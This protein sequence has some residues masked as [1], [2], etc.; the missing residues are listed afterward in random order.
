MS[1]DRTFWTGAEKELYSDLLLWRQQF[2]SWI[3][4]A[5]NRAGPRWFKRRISQWLSARP[6]CRPSGWNILIIWRTSSISEFEGFDHRFKIT[7]IPPYSTRFLKF[8]SDR[9]V[10]AP[11]LIRLFQ[12]PDPISFSEGHSIFP[13]AEVWWFRIRYFFEPG[14]FHWPRLFILGKR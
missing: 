14:I 9:E 2:S 8:I 10:F 3:C 7:N 12:K 5:S 1:L 6:G 13:G 4:S 11:S